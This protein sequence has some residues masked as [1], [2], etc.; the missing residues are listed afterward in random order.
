MSFVFL[1][2]ALKRSFDVE[3]VDA[4]P[5]FPPDSPGSTPG[6]GSLSPSLAFT[7]N[8]SLGSTAHHSHISLSS[9]PSPGFKSRMIGSSLSFNRGTMM[10]PVN[11]GS[12][13]TR[14]ASFQSR[15]NPNG[16]LMLSG[17]GSDNDSLHSSTSSLEYTSGGGS[18]FTKLGSYPSPP[19]HQQTHQ[20]GTP[21]QH[22][23]G[24]A[25]LGHN[26][27]LKKFSSHNNVFHSEVDQGPEVLLGPPES[28][29]VN[30]GSMPSLD[31][32]NCDRGGG[33]SS[34]QRGG[35]GANISPGLRYANANV[36]WN[37]C[38]H[39][40]T[41][42][43]EEGSK[44]NWQRGSQIPKTPKSKAKE[45]PRLNK[46]PLD[47]D[48]FV[49]STSPSPTVKTQD[50]YMNPNPPKPPLRSKGLQY[51]TSP[52]STPASCSASLSSLDSSTDTPPL[53][54]QQSFEPCYP[55]SPTHSQGSILPKEMSSPLGPF[56]PTQDPYLEI[57]SELKVVPEVSNWADPYSSS[58]SPSP[59]TAQSLEDGV[60]CT[61]DSVG[62]I[63]QRIASFQQQ[64]ESDSSPLVE[65]KSPA[66]QSNGG[67]P[68]SVGQH[69]RNTATLASLQGKKN[70]E[71][72]I[73]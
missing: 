24:R 29:G 10:K 12:S 15:L 38:L 60:E 61:R 70:K 30:H 33:M 41:L 22:Q 18:P 17:P 49:T 4:V 53:S 69:A 27:N 48:S 39:N 9:K 37:G 19:S 20:Q 54:T 72:M 56:S 16:Y 2:T 23:E 3:D 6:G 67:L 14:A 5:S 47:L 11:N 36:S 32:Q 65:V 45:T 26:P 8:N 34:M 66:V 63:L 64:I 35:V 28:L 40:N 1:P 58:G 13:V 57:L 25:N 31:L 50:G 44:T 51:P 43:G 62:S 59:G 46:F 42:F 55:C 68:S 71:G 73:L 7:G 52:P 21:Q